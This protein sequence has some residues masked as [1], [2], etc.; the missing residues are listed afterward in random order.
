MSVFKDWF[1]EKILKHPWII[2]TF[3][4]NYRIHMT[5]GKVF[6]FAGQNKTAYDA[7]C[8][9]ISARL[10][11]T[12]AYKLARRQAK[13][14][15][16]THEWTSFLF[17]VIENDKKCHAL[18]IMYFLED[19]TVLTGDERIELF[20]KAMHKHPKNVNLIEKFVQECI[21]QKRLED[22]K[23]KQILCYLNILSE[24]QCRRLL[25]DALLTSGI[26]QYNLLRNILSHPHLIIYEISDI[27]KKPIDHVEKMIET[28]LG[29]GSS[30]TS[31]VEKIKEN[32]RIG[33]LANHYSD[34]DLF[35]LVNK[36]ES[37]R[38]FC[39]KLAI[40]KLRVTNN[41][42]LLDRT[43]KHILSLNDYNNLN[44]LNLLLLGELLQKNC[45][46]PL[47]VN[48]YE[49][50]LKQNPQNIQVISRLSSCYRELGHLS[51]ALD[52]AK[53][54]LQLGANIG[55][56]RKVRILESE[57]NLLQ[58]IEQEKKEKCVQI[59][60]NK[61]I[62][63]PVL[64]VLNNSFPYSSNG[65]AVRSKY[66]VD[67]QSKLGMKPV[68]VT[69]L[70]FPDIGEKTNFNVEHVDGIPYYRLQ[71]DIYSF[72]RQPVNE[73]L[74]KY[75]EAILN[76]ARK[77]KPRLIHA[78][79]N[80]YNGYPALRC[81]QKLGIPFVYE[82]RGFWEMSR[83]SYIEGFEQSEKFNIHHYMEFQVMGQANHI[84]TISN[85]LKNYIANKGID[86]N[87]ITVVPNAVDT[88]FFT[89]QIADNQLVKK[90]ELS[91][92]T[93]IGF[94][95]SVT[96]YE[97]LNFLLNAVKQM[98]RIT[99]VK[100]LIVGNGEALEGL[101]ALAKHLNIDDRVIFTGRIPFKW[102]KNYYS[103]IDIFSFP[104]IRS[105]VCELVTPLKPYEAMAMEKTVLVSKVDALKEM[106]IDGETGLYFDPEDA[107]DLSNKLDFL[108]SQYSER[109]RLAANGRRWVQKNR[110][111]RIISKRYIPLYS[112]LS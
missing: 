60:H 69:R 89:P 15:R 99:D 102:V 77:V 40:E 58:T 97:G 104:R 66:I 93:V 2:Y 88:R 41:A 11:G 42:K 12:E 76:I 94:I 28:E 59:Y 57:L 49:K 111:W 62:D 101:K 110:D 39:L 14:L 56:K 29:E 10:D 38:A 83:S 20:L 71:K 87:K 45:R 70:G 95:G 7:F 108:V 3:P 24:R 103:V 65:Y 79:S 86:P 64:H 30:R 53:K 23:S 92:K 81:A 16:L 73:Y 47:A 50:M 78:A 98:K 80:F 84:V 51:K 68:V 32:L 74:Y 54:E 36:Y 75:E 18:P 26:F 43:A 91:G 105:K 48:L 82:V 13:S 22:L 63:Y 90:H 61:M 55:S 67:Y 27:N 1:I 6:Q 8:K 33:Y 100:V 19:D 109:K 37:L 25:N 46:Y 85:S 21:H 96:E 107:G 35:R 72:S 5:L 44:G 52:Y 17:D 31:I 4:A 106:V 9:A 34:D 112:S